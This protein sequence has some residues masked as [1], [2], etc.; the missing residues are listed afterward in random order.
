M[1][2]K[3]KVI[4]EKQIDWLAGEPWPDRQAAV[5]WR[6]VAIDQVAGVAA[7]GFD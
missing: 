1:L 5:G 2:F 3:C 7:R 4:E 6:P